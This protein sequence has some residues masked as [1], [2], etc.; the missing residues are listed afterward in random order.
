MTGKCVNCET[1]LECIRTME[2]HLT[3][4]NNSLSLATNYMDKLK[5]TVKTCSAQPRVVVTRSAKRKKTDKETDPENPDAVVVKN[6]ASTSSQSS[7]SHSS[8]NASTVVDNTNIAEL[9]HPNHSQPASVNSSEPINSDVTNYNLIAASNNNVVVDETTGLEAA[10]TPSL[11][12][13]FSNKAVYVTGVKIDTSPESVKDY[14][15]KTLG[16]SP[17]NSQIFVHK[18]RIDVSR[19]YSA[20]KIFVSSND[21]FDRMLSRDF[22][23]NNIV[24]YESFRKE[25][26]AHTTGRP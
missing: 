6:N 4:L 1:L 19:G 3:I 18:L 9:N 12:S 21:F 24:A 26:K 10:T 16:T 8:E 15:L 23:P 25:N 7:G 22:W 2:S 11:V 5:A 14:I 20:F 17:T 13:A